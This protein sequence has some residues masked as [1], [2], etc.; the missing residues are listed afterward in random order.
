MVERVLSMHEV[1]GSMPRISIF[2]FPF[3]KAIFLVLC[4][5]VSTMH[6]SPTLFFSFFRRGFNLLEALWVK[7]NINYCIVCRRGLCFYLHVSNSVANVVI[8]AWSPFL[9]TSSSSS[10]SLISSHP[11]PFSSFSFSPL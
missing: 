7:I 5:G 2:F 8:H 6:E 4:V 3:S 10:S 9:S 1:R 11:S